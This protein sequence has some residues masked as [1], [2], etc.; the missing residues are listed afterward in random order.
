MVDKG[1]SPKDIEQ[2]F[3]IIRQGEEAKGKKGE[4]SETEGQANPTGK[5]EPG[6]SP[7]TR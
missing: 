6:P 1:I 7:W 4:T 3:K 2:R 5:E